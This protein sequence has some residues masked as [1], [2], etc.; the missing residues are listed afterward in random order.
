MYWTLRDTN[1][2]RVGF[3]DRVNI[4]LSSEFGPKPLPFRRSTLFVDNVMFCF[5]IVIDWG[6]FQEAIVSAVAVDD[7]EQ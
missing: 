3:G 4:R 7:F 5:V 1:R 2:L 6:A